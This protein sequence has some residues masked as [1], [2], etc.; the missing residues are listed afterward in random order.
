MAVVIELWEDGKRI[1]SS[2]KE[3]SDVILPREGEELQIKAW[4]EKINDP[5]L[6]FKISAIVHEWHYSPPRIRLYVDR[7]H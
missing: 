3:T 2:V 4:P 1:H 7:R 6:I 5:I